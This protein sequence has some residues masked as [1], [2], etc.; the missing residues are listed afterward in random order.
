MSAS[1]PSD[2]RFRGGADAVSEL[3]RV[4]LKVPKTDD[5]MFYFGDLVPKRIHSPGS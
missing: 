2:T 5:L 1:H 4:M 3:R